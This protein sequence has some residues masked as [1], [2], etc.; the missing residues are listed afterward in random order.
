MTMSAAIPTRLIARIPA[1]HSTGE[2]AVDDRSA[3]WVNVNS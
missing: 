1:G 3:A 2:V